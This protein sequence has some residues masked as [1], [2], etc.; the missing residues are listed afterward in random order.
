MDSA[1]R[2]RQRDDRMTAHKQPKMI[3]RRERVLVAL[4][5][6]P[7]PLIRKEALARGWQ[8]VNLFYFSLPAG[9]VPDGALVTGLPDAERVLGLRERG[10]PVV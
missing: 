10:V 1:R 7:D 9:V 2:A 3:P 8:L 6:Q 5:L 4:A